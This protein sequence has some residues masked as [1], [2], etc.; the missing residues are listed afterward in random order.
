MIGHSTDAYRIAFKTAVMTGMRAG[1]LWG[2]Q[3]GNI[4]GN[5]G[6]IYVRRSLWGSN[7]QTPKSKT[8][9]RKI[10]IPQSLIFEL[11]KWKLACPINKYDLVFPNPDGEFTVHNTAIKSHFNPALRLAGLRHVSFHSLRHSNASMRIQGG[12]NIKYLST[13]LGH[14]SINIT[15]DRYGHLFNDMDFTR[16]QVELLEDS[17]L[18]VRKPLEEGKKEGLEVCAVNS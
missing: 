13:Q 6:Q 14:S 8:S 3:W 2:L 10:D 18:S 11:K 17:F 1:E 4:D 15:M 5:A 7:F 16:Q 9:I 12:Q